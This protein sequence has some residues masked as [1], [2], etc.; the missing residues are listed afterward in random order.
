[1][2]FLTDPRI[3]P[4]NNRA[5]R[6]LRSAVIARKVSHGSKNDGIAHAFAPF[7]HIVW[8]RAKYDALVVVDAL[9]HLSQ[10]R[11]LHGA[12]PLTPCNQ[13]C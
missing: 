10:I 7:T 1:V 13:S 11:S 8:T 3:E 9:D 4:I 6:A 5:E 12:P 2:R